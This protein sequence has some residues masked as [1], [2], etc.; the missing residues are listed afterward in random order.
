MIGDALVGVIFVR[1]AL[2]AILWIGIMP[3][4]GAKGVNNALIITAAATSAVLLLPIPLLIWGRKGRA[5][6]AAK[7]KE[8]SLA[9]TPPATLSR[10][11]GENTF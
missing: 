2:A 4:V 3:W 7:Y 10:I 9:A 1:N 11:M 8:Y 5:A 6:T